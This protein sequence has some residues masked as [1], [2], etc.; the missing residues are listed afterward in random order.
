MDPVPYADPAVQREYQRVRIATR[1]A[2]WLAVNGP[3]RQCGSVD[4]LEID[5]IDPGQKVSHRIWSW[6]DTR[7]L[8]ELE[9]CQ[10][11]CRSCHMIKSL[12][13]VDLAPHGTHQCYRRGCRCDECR[14]G[15]AS[16][17]ARYR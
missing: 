1:R 7:L 13:A 17:N 2:A 10:V 11:L 15:H 3:C 12:G 14:A 9:K 16:H 4:Q 6:S 8:A 5:H